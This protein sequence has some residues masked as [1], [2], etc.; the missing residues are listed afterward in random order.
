[1]ARAKISKDEKKRIISE[2][3]AAQKALREKEKEEEQASLQAYKSLSKEEKAK[4]AADKKE[5][6]K[7]KK[8]EAEAE[9][10]KQKEEKAKAKAEKKA[11]LASLSEEDR[12]AY[13]AK[14]KAE[15]KQ[16][17]SLKFEEY[18]KEHAAKVQQK[19]A[20]LEARYDF[21]AY[22][23]L[24]F[25]NLGQSGFSQGY[26]NWWRKVQISHPSLAKWLYQIF[27]FIIFS[28]GVTVL[29]FLIMLFLPYAFQSLSATAFVWP[30][31]TLWAWDAVGFDGATNMIF[32]IF[33]EPV[34]T[35]NGVVQANGGLGN[36]IAYEIAVFTAQCINFPLQRNITYKSHGNPWYQAMWY[37][38]GWVL[39]SI[40]CNVCWGFINPI[41]LHFMD[42][43]GGAAAIYSLIKTVLTGGISM[44]IFFFIFQV[45]FPSGV[46]EETKDKSS[47]KA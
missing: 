47:I 26:M 4:I 20:A 23:H 9:A 17:D 39:I 44:V 38:I 18:K 34:V 33:N 30:S 31:V 7:Q 41:L 5:Q 27:F 14:E 22:I 37:F 15:K 11:H 2:Y 46:K 24:F 16:Q 13:I 6:A 25:F 40:F 28:E 12:K 21:G 3:K 32:G 10:K 36:F 1:M 43:N 42:Y 35:V 29:Q 19:R 8:I 45:I